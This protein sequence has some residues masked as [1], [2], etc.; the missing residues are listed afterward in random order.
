VSWACVTVW[1]AV[2][3]RFPLL[4]H[5]A[6]DS[7]TCWCLCVYSRS[8]TKVTMSVVDCHL[9]IRNLRSRIRLG[10]DWAVALEVKV[11]GVT[12]PDP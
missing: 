7:L 3:T 10:L 1:W 12:L 4:V 9:V 11:G 5:F 6:V 8:F 2:N